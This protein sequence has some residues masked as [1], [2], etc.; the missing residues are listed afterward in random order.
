[1][2][3]VFLTTLILLTTLAAVADEVTF[4]TSAPKAVVVNQQFRLKYTVNRHNV[5]E[6]RLPQI[7]DFRI[8]SGPSRSQ[9]SSTQII[10]GNVTSSQSLTFTYILPLKVITGG[11]NRKH[12]HSI[13]EKNSK[14]I[15]ISN[16]LMS[17]SILPVVRFWRAVQFIHSLNAIPQKSQSILTVLPVLSPR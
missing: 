12:L 13:S 6:P 17:I 16:K 5:K 3:K 15:K 10:N 2:K 4:V 11:K 8:L 1:M 9:Q 14:N 7:S